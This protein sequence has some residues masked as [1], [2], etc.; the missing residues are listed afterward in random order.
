MAHDAARA[1]AEAT[2]AGSTADP[3]WSFEAL[4]RQLVDERTFPLL[5]RIAWSAEIG[6]NPSG[7][8]EQEEFLFGVDRIL[9][10]TQVLID[11]VREHKR[12]PKGS[13][14]RS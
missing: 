12:R 11:Q 14:Q 9:D 10:G 5:H 6:G 2:A 3:A 7:F 4:L 8:E 13:G 1:A